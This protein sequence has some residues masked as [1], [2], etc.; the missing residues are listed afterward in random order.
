[1]NLVED[2]GIWWQMPKYKNVTIPARQ[3]GDI[4]ITERHGSNRGWPGPEREVKY[5]VELENGWAVGIITPKKG[6]AS[7]PMY[8][9]RPSSMSVDAE[10]FAC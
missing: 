8:Q 5:W 10:E 9:M 6:N 3:F 2:F 4:E 1:M 7:F